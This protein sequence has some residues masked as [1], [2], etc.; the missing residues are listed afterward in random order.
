MTTATEADVS[1]TL[2]G[3]DAEPGHENRKTCRVFAWL[4][5][6]MNSCESCGLPYWEHMYVP[7][8]GRDKPRF[9]VR[10]YTPWNDHWHW[11]P[12]GAVITREQAELVKSRWERHG[13]SIPG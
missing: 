2:R 12:V 7:P 9:Y 13:S 11:E 4:G 8:L 3:R 10:Q 6:S 1:L 5:Q